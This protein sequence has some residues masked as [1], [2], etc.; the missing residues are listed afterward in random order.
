M[1]KSKTIKAFVGFG[2]KD[3]KEIKVYVHGNYYVKHGGTLISMTFDVK[4]LIDGV[5]LF[6]IYDSNCILVKKLIESEEDLI[7]AIES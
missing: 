4:A 2:K 3:R 1:E 6:D 7:K 5:N